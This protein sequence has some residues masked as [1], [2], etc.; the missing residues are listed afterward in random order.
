MVMASP[1][2]MPESPLDV[3]SRAAS[4]LES[5]SNTSNLE[6]EEEGDNMMM[7][8][9]NSN[10]SD[11]DTHHQPDSPPQV[12]YICTINNQRRACATFITINASF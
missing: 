9:S 6:E 11:N 4:M 10:S 1:E 2:V 7:D 5:V 12:R 3:L 8:T